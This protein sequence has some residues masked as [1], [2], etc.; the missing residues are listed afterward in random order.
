[1]GLTLEQTNNLNEQQWDRLKV[2]AVLH[3]RLIGE[4]MNFPLN[5]GDTQED[6]IEVLRRKTEIKRQIDAL[7]KERD[8]ILGQLA[9]ETIG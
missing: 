8:R 9:I 4:Y 6:T 2:M 7:R 5:G 3:T 1:M